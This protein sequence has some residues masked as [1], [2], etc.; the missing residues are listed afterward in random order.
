M[1]LF[2]PAW[3]SKNW[4]RATKAVKKIKKEAK[5]ARV[6][7]EAR[8]SEARVAAVERLTDQDVLAYVAKNDEDRAVR[9]AAVEKLT[10]QDILAYIAKINWYSDVGDAAFK[11]LT[12]QNVLVDF[13]MNDEKPWF[14]KAAVKKLTDLK[15]TD[16]AILELLISKFPDIDLRLKIF[17]KLPYASRNLVNNLEYVLLIRSGNFQERKYAANELIGMLKRNRK[18]AAIFWNEV[19]EKAMIAHEDS[20]NHIDR[21]DDYSEYGHTDSHDDFYKHTDC[22]IG[23]DFPPY[24]FEDESA[25]S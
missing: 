8:C 5:L 21:H 23:V 3:D 19:R 15:K 9:V 22:G 20:R 14:R 12:D 24:P 16:T 4:E 2:R 10:D 7:K 6:A 1:G 11:K 17:S 13:A 18:A 25:Q